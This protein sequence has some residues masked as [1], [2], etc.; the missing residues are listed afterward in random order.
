MLQYVESQ[1]LE[2]G[3]P[4]CREHLESTLET[5]LHNQWSNLEFLSSL[6]EQEIFSKRQ[7]GYD[8]RLRISGLPYRKSISEFDFN[9]A[10][11]VD[12]KVV[13]ELS[14]LAFLERASNVCLLGPPGVGKTHIA[15][16]LAMCAIEAGK[17]VYF[18]QMAKMTQELGHSPSART[19]S[20]YLKPKLLILDEI[21][22]RNVDPRAGGLFFDVRNR[23]ET[24]W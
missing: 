22:Y 19:L 24:N 16:S 20:K 8:M 18:T 21:G 9:F 23:A 11:G 7:R 12:K 13:T 2:L 14:S 4:S 5:A 1:L 17:S 6:M 3:L 10:S 15:L